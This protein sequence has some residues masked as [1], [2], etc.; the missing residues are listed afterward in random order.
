[1]CRPWSSSCRQS[2]RETLPTILWMPH[3]RGKDTGSLAS[4]LPAS[5]SPP[6]PSSQQFQTSCC[7]FLKTFGDNGGQERRGRCWPH[8][9][10]PKGYSWMVL[11]DYSQQCSG[12]QAVP[13]IKPKPLRCKAGAG[14]LIC[15]SSPSKD[16]PS[17]THFII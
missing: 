3:H 5:P 8:L 1:M 9:A 12:D 10:V 7:G 6:S 14:V 4:A 17:F 13:G 11:D 2:P 16:I 15:L